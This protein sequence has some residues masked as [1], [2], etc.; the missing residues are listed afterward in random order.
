MFLCSARSPD[1]EVNFYVSVPPT[2]VDQVGNLIEA[3]TS[4]LRSL[5]AE[6]ESRRDVIVFPFAGDKFEQTK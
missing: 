6:I 3:P 2:V 4:Q 1:I 5:Q